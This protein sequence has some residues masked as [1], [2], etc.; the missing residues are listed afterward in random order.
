MTCVRDL[1][2]HHVVTVSA[3]TSCHDAVGMLARN[4]I[5][6]LPVVDGDGRLC[7]IVTDRDLRHHLFDPEVFHAIGTEPV[8][9]L[10]ARVAVHEVMSSPVTSI[11]AGASL[12]EAA[13]RLRLAARMRA[14]L[15]A[16]P[17]RVTSARLTFTDQ[18]GPRGGPAVRCAATV[19]LAGWGRLHVEDDDATPELALAGALARL[20]RRLD[21]RRELDRE[22]G[23]RPK[24][25]YA[26]ARAQRAAAT[27]TAGRRR[28]RG[29]VS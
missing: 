5:R 2:S 26:A 15:A 23:R 6:H 22:R 17:G 12:D 14:T 3:A 11:D 24:K 18:D 16:L 27:A 7:G 19:T 25:Y 4:R 28:R 13:R 10:L 1:M 8:E 20:Q 21:R 9:Q 29:A